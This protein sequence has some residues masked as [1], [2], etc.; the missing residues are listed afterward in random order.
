MAIQG[1]SEVRRLPRLGIIRLGEKAK[2][3]SGVEYPKKLDYFNL[4]DAPGV[5]AVFGEKPKTI[6]IMLPHENIDVFFP[7]WRKAYGKSTGLFCKGNGDRASRVRLGFADGESGKDG[8]PSR[9]KKGEAFDPEGEAFIKAQGIQVAIGKRFDMPCLGEECPYTKRKTCKPL[10]QFMFLIPKVPGFGCFQISTTSFNSM[11]D[12]NSYIEAVRAAAGR[13]SMIPLTLSLVPK[14]VTVNNKATGI[15]HLKLEYKGQLSELV[16]YRDT[17]YIAADLL[18]QLEHEAPEDL[19]PEQGAALDRALG[20]S[21]E[22]AS[23]TVQQPDPEPT[24]DESTPFDEMP[25]KT[26]EVM[27]RAPEPTAPPAPP[28]PVVKP[29]LKRKLL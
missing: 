9:L 25:A 26:A 1:I 18:P 4:K 3:N 8:K 19:M 11:V 20:K 7:Q 17:A 23:P 27:P 6:E 12:L 5:A 13:V 16:R 22:D 24:F 14:K 10:A 15:F 28:A 29:T 2:N 21:S